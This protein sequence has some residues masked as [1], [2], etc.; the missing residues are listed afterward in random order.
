MG[1]IKSTIIKRT[2][3]TLISDNPEFTDKFEANKKI[4]ESYELPDKGTKNKIAGYIVRIKRAGNIP[5]PRKHI[6][7]ND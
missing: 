3:K 2:A 6:E 4:L 5:K 1:R 7:E